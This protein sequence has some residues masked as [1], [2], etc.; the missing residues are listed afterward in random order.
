MKRERSRSSCSSST[1]RKKQAVEEEGSPGS[2]NQDENARN[3]NEEE[4][5]VT[6]ALPINPTCSTNNTITEA[7]AI[8]NSPMTEIKNTDTPNKNE[9]QASVEESNLVVP[10]RSRARKSRKKPKRLT[11][12]RK[13]SK[14]TPKKKVAPPVLSRSRCAGKVL[15]N[16]RRRPRPMEDFPPSLPLEGGNNEE[17]EVEERDGA[18]SEDDVAAIDFQEE[19]YFTAEGEDI[20]IDDE[21]ADG[22]DVENIL[23]DYDSEGMPKEKSDE[24]VSRLPA[25]LH[26]AR[27]RR[28]RN[29]YAP[30][31]L[32]A[33]NLFTKFKGK[34]LNNA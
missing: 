28:F 31:S 32:I 15:L 25:G 20:F 33:Q 22:S 13:Y 14:S 2:A 21:N 8:P 7:A 5:Q 9:V 12:P 23:S 29:A 4:G 3:D 34:T 1:P 26:V 17:N 10:G 30:P 11:L 18:P 6:T 16:F 24:M 27:R 19:A